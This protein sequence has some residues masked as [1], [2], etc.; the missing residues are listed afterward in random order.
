MN[1]AVLLY[2]FAYPLLLPW[3]HTY[4]CYVSLLW[5]SD[6]HHTHTH[7]NGHHHVASIRWLLTLWGQRLRAVF[8]P[9]CWA[10]CLPLSD[11][12]H[13][14]IT[15]TRISVWVRVCVSWLNGWAL[16]PAGLEQNQENIL[17][18]DMVSRR[19]LGWNHSRA[20]SR[21]NQQ[22]ISGHHNNEFNMSFN[23]NAASPGQD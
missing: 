15:V 1:T 4:T 6:L 16:R 3:I 23:N 12:C 7:P 19:G 20:V 9:A 5:S 11:S 17:Y 13:Y 10:L 22:F 21:K 14:L 2:F 18:D 8:L